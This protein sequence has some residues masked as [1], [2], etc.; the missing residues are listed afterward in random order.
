MC[1]IKGIDKFNF[2][3]SQLIATEELIDAIRRFQKVSDPARLERI[4]DVIENLDKDRDG[5]VHVE[6]VLKASYPGWIFIPVYFLLLL[7]Y[8]C[9]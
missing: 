4:A 8:L 7:A 9:L 5:Q 3:R 2:I 1:F 6:D